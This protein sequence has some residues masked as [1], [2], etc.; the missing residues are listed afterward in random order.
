MTIKLKIKKYNT[1][2]KEKQ[3]EYLSTGKIDK[4]EYLTGKETLPSDQS[5]II[6]P[7]KF[8]YS[9]FGIAFEKQIKTIEGQAEKTNKDTRRALKTTS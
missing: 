2:L 4:Y 5:T 1:V 8:T 3:Q 9:P 6:E 7:A